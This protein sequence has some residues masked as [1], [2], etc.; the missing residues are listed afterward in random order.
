M[1]GELLLRHLHRV[2]E[3]ER[4]GSRQDAKTPREEICPEKFLLLASWRLGG[5]LP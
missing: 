3:R 2:D 1:R 5:S 4:E